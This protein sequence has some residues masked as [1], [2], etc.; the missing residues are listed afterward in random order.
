LASTADP[1]DSARLCS[2]DAWRVVV[3]PTDLQSAAAWPLTCSDAQECPLRALRELMNRLGHRSTRA[4]LLHL[5]A[6]DK[7][8]QEIATGLNAMVTKLTGTRPQTL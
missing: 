2:A 5:H 4:A 3:T 7:R 6:R 8:D 1:L